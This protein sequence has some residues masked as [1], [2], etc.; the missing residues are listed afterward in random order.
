LLARRPNRGHIGGGGWTPSCGSCLRYICLLVTTCHAKPP[1]LGPAQSYFVDT[2]AFFL[3]QK[4]ARVFVFLSFF[5]QKI[6]VVLQHLKV[7]DPPSF[8]LK[9][10]PLFEHDVPPVCRCFLARKSWRHK[11]FSERRSLR[12]VLLRGCVPLLALTG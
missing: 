7:Q 1:R 3:R 6:A 5:S 11:A 4:S 9:V 2:G 8:W 10:L 12:D